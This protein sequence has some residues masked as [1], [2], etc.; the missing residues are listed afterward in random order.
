MCR[1]PDP[2]MPESMIA[3]DLLRDRAY[4]EYYFTCFQCIHKNFS[5]PRLH[6]FVFSTVE[7]PNWKLF[8][9]LRNLEL[10]HETDF[11]FYTILFDKGTI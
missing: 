5:L 1:A 9:N 6:G 2:H 8:S 10:K 4:I 11:R 7:S 3:D